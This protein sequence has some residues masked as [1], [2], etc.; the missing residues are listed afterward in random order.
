MTLILL[1]SLS[2]FQMREYGSPCLL[3]HLLYFLL[4]W[5]LNFFDLPAFLLPILLALS[6]LLPREHSPDQ[7]PNLIGGT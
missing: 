4:V 1:S 5:F 6:L 3:M 7:I 2:L